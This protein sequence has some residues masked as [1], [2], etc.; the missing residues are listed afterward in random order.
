MGGHLNILQA[1]NS[2]LGFSDCSASSKS[3]EVV[4]FSTPGQAFD[5]CGHSHNSKYDLGRWKLRSTAW[6]AHDAGNTCKPRLQWHTNHCQTV[7]HPR[8]LH[9]SRVP[10]DPLQLLHFLATMPLLL[11]LHCRTEN[12]QFG[13]YALHLTKLL[14]TASMVVPDPNDCS[15]GEH[16]P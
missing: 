16:I 12:T 11:L 8:L 14:Q 7:Q 15:G 10:T 13:V 5:L 4:H 1:S 2:K 9:N 6:I 3:F